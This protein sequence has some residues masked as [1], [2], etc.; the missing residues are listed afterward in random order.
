MALVVILAFCLSF[1]ACGDPPAEPPSEEGW[2]QS[3]YGD[4][5]FAGSPDGAQGAGILMEM[6]YDTYALGDETISYTLANTTPDPVTFT[7]E[8]TLEY[9]DESA[10]LTVPFI[11]EPDPGEGYTLPGKQMCRVDVELSSF[12]CDFEEGRYRIVRETGGSLNMA[13]FAIGPAKTDPLDMD[14]GYRPLETLPEGYGAGDAIADGCYV[15]AEGFV[16]EED[17]DDS[18]PDS[19]GAAEGGAGDAV[20][21]EG[22]A[23]DGGDATEED[24]GEEDG[25]AVKTSPF[26][27]DILQQF[28]D[29]AWLGVPAKLRTFI[30]P[31]EGEPQIRDIVFSPSPEGYGRYFV[32]YKD[33]SADG[34]TEGT[35]AADAAETPD[36]TDDTENPDAPEIPADQEAAVGPGPIYSFLSVAWVGGVS[37]ICLSNYVSHKDGA[38]EEAPLELVSPETR[39]DPDMVATT[40][41]RMEESL[42]ALPHFYLAFAADGVS[43]VSIIQ[44]GGSFSYKCGDVQK[45][46]ISPGNVSVKFTGAAWISPTRFSLEGDTADGQS[47]SAVY[48]AEADRIESSQT[49]G[50]SAE[51]EEDPPEE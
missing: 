33:A 51:E 45:A 34:D 3:L 21:A 26:N 37:K 18:D 19:D 12:D 31:E 22:G 17:A 44:G 39:D 41:Y 49:S 16:P 27:R 10:W 15:I 9:M 50:P 38:T 4:S 24:D 23:A 28:M 46:S 47:Y 8:Y 13:E 2:P 7:D 29:K 35:D 6:A 32:A 25:D 30:L 36:G 48:D 20:G 1:C 42:S 11:S 14:F 5:D 43:W 40:E